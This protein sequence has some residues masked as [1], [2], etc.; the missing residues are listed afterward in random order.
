[1]KKGLTQNNCCGIVKS[2]NQ[3][4]KGFERVTEDY[5]LSERGSHR[6]KDSC[7]SDNS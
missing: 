4:N 6:M 1:M 7:C 2:E 5:F 3:I